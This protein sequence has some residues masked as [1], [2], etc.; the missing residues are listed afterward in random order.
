MSETT[1][2]RSARVAAAVNAVK[3]IADAIR[4]LG[5]VPAGQLY[6]IVCGHFS[7]GDF[8]AIIGI[9]CRA[10]L[11]KRDPSGLLHWIA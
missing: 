7:L 10:G 5:Q 6:A 8:D 11:V 4:E 3:A 1:V 9:L 2:S